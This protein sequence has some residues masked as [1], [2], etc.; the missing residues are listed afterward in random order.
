VCS[1]ATQV[2]NPNQLPFLFARDA[3]AHGDAHRRHVTA[4]VPWV[5]GD[6]EDDAQGFFSI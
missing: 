1:I 2:D 4:Q 5:V 3:D 6:R